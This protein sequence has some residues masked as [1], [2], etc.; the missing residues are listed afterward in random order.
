MQTLERGYADYDIDMEAWAAPK[1]FGFS[2][3]FRLRDEAEFMRPAI[4]SHLPYLD[5]A[6]LVVQESS[7]ETVEYAYELEREYPEKVRV[8]EYPV[9]PRF[10]DHPEWLT[11]PENSIYSFVYLSNWALS[12][13]RFSWIVKVEGDVICLP[14]FQAIIDKIN[15][16]G[17]PWY[18]GR[19]VLNAAGKDCNL[20]SVEN[21]RN[22][23]WDEAV[24]P[25]HPRA[26][27]VR[28][29]KWEVLIHDLR[30]T[31]YGWSG[32]HMKR[33]KRE[34]LPGPWNGETYKLLTWDNLACALYKHNQKTE[35]IGIDDPLGIP[36]LFGGWQT[37]LTERR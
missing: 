24:I 31:C 4:L 14:T 9:I 27:F 12:R 32:V 34:L 17:E 11:T 16:S 36:E 29:Q 25:N 20:F 28:R 33:C 3:C 7:D 1:P 8:F 6:V 22:G 15:G 10:I 2:G 37:W 30:S 18:Y 23:G 13:C 5:E 21:P 19:V 26:Y 35:Y